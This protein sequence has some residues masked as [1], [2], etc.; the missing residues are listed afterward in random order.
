MYSNYRRLQR[1]LNM[2][3]PEAFYSIGFDDGTVDLQG[4][5][6]SELNVK[7]KRLKFT[8]DYAR[9]DSTGYIHLKRGLVRICLT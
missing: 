7:L 8:Y 9:D 1:V 2:I 6:S 3:T 4:R 5:Y